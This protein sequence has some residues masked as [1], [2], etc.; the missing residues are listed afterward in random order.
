MSNIRHYFVAALLLLAMLIPARHAQAETFNTCAGFIDSIPAVVGTQGVWCLRKD[1]ATNLTGVN[2]IEIATN[3]ATIDCNGFKL[4]NLAAGVG[5]FS[6]GI[7]AYERSNITVR[8]CNIR[9]FR[10]GIAVYGNDPG[11]GVLVE[12]NI[13]EGNTSYGI[14]AMNYDAIVQGNRVLNTG[15]SPGATYNQ[16]ISSMGDVIVNVIDGVSGSTDVENS[17]AFGIYAGG[18]GGSVQD[19]VVVRGNRI[20]NLVPTGAGN[21][22]GISTASYMSVVRDNVMVES[23]PTSGMG[24]YCNS[25]LLFDNVIVNFSTGNSGCIDKSG[26]V[27]N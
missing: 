25:G 17:S 20:R 23:V 11:S 21:V 7:Y 14:Y 8:N 16:A 13:L 19:G 3:N 18:A 2:A 1:L 4:G 5:T 26:N 24:M 22:R 6:V 15:G 12:D 9:G 10:W 27:I